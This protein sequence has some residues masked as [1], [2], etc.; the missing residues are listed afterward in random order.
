MH[1]A[2]TISEHVHKVKSRTGSAP[3]S[4]TI[5]IFEPA[6]L[7]FSSRNLRQSSPEKLDEIAGSTS[8]LR[9]QEGTC[10]Q[11][12]KKAL[13]V[14]RSPPV[15]TVRKAAAGRTCRCGEP[16]SMYLYSLERNGRGD[17]NAA[18]AVKLDLQ[19][20]VGRNLCRQS[21]VVASQNCSRTLDVASNLVDTQLKSRRIVLC[22]SLGCLRYPCQP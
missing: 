18:H 2:R 4:A 19:L 10:I 11:S 14:A 17:V 12:T 6:G 15:A 16:G 7:T 20:Q 22:D 1:K 8:P 3:K 9:S 21:N 5:H 13:S